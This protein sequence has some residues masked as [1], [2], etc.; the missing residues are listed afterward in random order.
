[1]IYISTGIYHCFIPD[2]ELWSLRSSLPSRIKRKVNALYVKID[3]PKMPADYSFSYIR[4]SHGFTKRNNLLDKGKNK[5]R[6]KYPIP[7]SIFKSQIAIK[8]NNLTIP[9]IRGSVRLFFIT[10]HGYHSSLRTYPLLHPGRNKCVLSYL[11]TPSSLP[12][13]MNASTQASS[14]SR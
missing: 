7:L 8:K 9:R 13:L 3:I 14:S 2:F 10:G 11:I 4:Y 12:T 5:F 1:M 6:T